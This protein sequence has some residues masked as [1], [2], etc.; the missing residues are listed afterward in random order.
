MDKIFY[1][2]MDSSKKNYCQ[3][4]I[5]NKISGFVLSLELCKIKRC[6]VE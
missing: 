1:V 5:N 4:S 3:I 6:L 2:F